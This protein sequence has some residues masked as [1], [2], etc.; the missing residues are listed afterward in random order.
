MQWGI[1]VPVRRRGR[2]L[3]EPPP[4]VIAPSVRKTPL[5][6]NKCYAAQQ[7]PP[8]PSLQRLSPTFALGVKD[9]TGF[10]AKA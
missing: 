7:L 4:P 5:T 6:A 3:E 10:R 2:S 1:A 9:I 8:S